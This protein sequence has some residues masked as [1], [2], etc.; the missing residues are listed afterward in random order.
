GDP[1]H[2]EQVARQLV[3]EL[4]LAVVVDA[5]VPVIAKPRLQRHQAVAVE[6][7]QHPAVQHQFLME[8]A[9]LLG[10]PRHQTSS[11]LNMA[12]RKAGSI[13]RSISFLMT[14]PSSSVVS[15]TDGML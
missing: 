2:I 10:C 9:L 14:L 4:G 3:E 11:T 5:L 12:S 7:A 15:T 1:V 8:R 13:W 6:M